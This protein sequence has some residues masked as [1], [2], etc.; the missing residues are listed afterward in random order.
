MEILIFYLKK[1]NVN[2]K[3][4]TGSKSGNTLFCVLVTFTVIILIRV[5]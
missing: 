5:R 3:S 1:I 4:S 2:V